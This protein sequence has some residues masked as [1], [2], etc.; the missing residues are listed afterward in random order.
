MQRIAIFM[1]G[2]SAEHEIS[3]ISALNI[4]LSLDRERFEPLLIGIDKEGKWWLQDEQRLREQPMDPKQIQL[5]D[6]DRPVAV[7]P[8]ASA[9]HFIDLSTG[10]PLPDPV[11]VFAILHGPNGEDGSIQGLLQ[12]L[13]LPYVGPD[14]LG[15]AVCMDKDV[16]KRLMTEAGI[17]NAAFR[18]FRAWE[19]AQISFEDLTQ[20]LQPPLF[21]KPAR[22]GS[23]VGISKVQNAAEL[24][25]AVELAFRFD[26]KIVIEEGIVG[27]E[28]EVA[29][30]GNEDPKA[31]VIGEIV[32]EVDFYDY[33]S[34]YVSADGATLLLPAPDM[35]EATIQR[36]REAAIHAYQTLECEGL[37]RVDYFLCE[38]G[39]LMLNEINTLPGFTKISM[40]PSLWG[41]TGIPYSDLIT[42]LIELAIDR[43]RALDALQV[44]Q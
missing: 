33:E 2:K 10:K 22:M 11:A 1:G 25:A 44:S 32:P 31:S 23:S 20:A 27:R 36:V 29:V 16:A 42:Q 43:Q 12:H 38:D 19:Q 13:H 40:Y 35:D 6:T 8:G 17:P 34:K 4:L 3:L 15:S 18:T 37:S 41:L 14:L 28:I 24:K 21:V 30:L 39:S 5:P 26:R 9:P 7:V